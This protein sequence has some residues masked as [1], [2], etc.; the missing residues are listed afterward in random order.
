MDCQNNH[1]EV[2]F[3]GNSIFKLIPYPSWIKNNPEQ[4]PLKQKMY[5]TDLLLL[6]E[7]ENLTGKINLSGPPDTDSEYTINQVFNLH[8]TLDNIPLSKL[9]IENIF[10]PNTKKLTREPLQKYQNLD[11]V[12]RQLK[13]W[14]FYKTKPMKADMNSRK[15]NSSKIL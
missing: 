5:R 1:Y 14:H 15:Q 9:Q 6:I 4:K 2:D 10:L 12:I 8:D 3:F 7:K 13:S 11:P